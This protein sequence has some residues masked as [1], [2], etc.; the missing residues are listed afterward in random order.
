[1][2]LRERAAS[3]PLNVRID[4][5]LVGVGQVGFHLGVSVESGLLVANCLAES[6]ARDAGDRVFAAAAVRRRGTAGHV[7]KHALDV[8]VAVAGGELLPTFSTTKRRISAFVLPDGSMS[9]TSALALPM[10]STRSATRASVAAASG[11]S[12]LVAVSSASL[13]PSVSFNFATSASL[14]SIAVLWSAM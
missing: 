10:T 13:A 5:L 1:M 3:V 14:A 4:R 2:G 8:L 7:V 6:V 11:M 12:F 9:P